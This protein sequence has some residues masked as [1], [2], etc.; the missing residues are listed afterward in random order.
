MVTLRLRDLIL[1][2]DTAPGLFSQARIDTGTMALLTAAPD[3]PTGNLLDLGCGYGPIALAVARRQPRATVWAVDIDDRAL[4]LTERNAE[5]A[6]L[7]N[8]RAVTPRQVPANLT[9]AAIYS[10]PPYRLGR[11]AMLDLLATWFDRLD[12]GG[13]AY[14]VVR[15][16]NGADSLA[17]R[18]T[19]RGYPTERLASKAGYRVLMWRRG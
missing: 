16:D 5:R 10:N 7:T 13:A 19:E 9:F 15:R 4:E 12:R 14:I 1:D 6:S 17:A 18:L 8:V 2:L 3:P 11:P